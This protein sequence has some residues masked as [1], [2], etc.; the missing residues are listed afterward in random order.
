MTWLDLLTVAL[1]V[2]VGFVEA[3]RGAVPAA[4]DLCV[5]L[6]G[7]GLAKR[8]APNLA[9]WVGSQTTAFLLLLVSVVAAAVVASWL[10]DTYTKWEIGPYD[11]AVAGAVGVVSG[12]VLAH[13][14][15]HA[16][17]VSGGGLEAL[18]EKSLLAPEV[19]HLQTL[20]A[21]GDL[22]RNLGGGKT[23]SEKVREQQQ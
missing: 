4:A 21:I 22:L 6:V 19:Y 3:K 2:L 11:A 23:I 18:A 9:A 15:F 17:M 16:A 5:G 8:L 14:V 1:F 13:G 7:I 20:H 12:L 10:L